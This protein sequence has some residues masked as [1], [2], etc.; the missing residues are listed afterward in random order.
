M[1]VDGAHGLLAQPLDL[2][3]SGADYY[4]SNCHK[5]FSSPKGAAFLWAKEASTLSPLVVSHGYG[6]GTWSGFAWDG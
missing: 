3:Q 4:V 2:P 1:L 6:E 5:W